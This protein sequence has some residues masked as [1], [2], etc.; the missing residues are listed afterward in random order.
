[1]KPVRAAA[2]LV[3]GVASI[4]L[5]SASAGQTRFTLTINIATRVGSGTG[6]VS[7]RPG[8]INCP[9]TCSATYLLGAVVTL[10][11]QAGP[12]SDFSGWPTACTVAGTTCTVAMTRD[13]TLDVSF[14]RLRSRQ[15][16]LLRDVQKPQGPPPPSPTILL[17]WGSCSPVPIRK[18]VTTNCPLYATIGNAQLGNDVRVDLSEPITDHCYVGS[19]SPRSTAIPEHT[20]PGRLLVTNVALTHGM[21][22]RASAAR[23]RTTVFLN[24]HARVE[25]QS[26][27]QRRE[28]EKVL[29]VPEEVEGVK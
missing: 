11:A 15:S 27:G 26:G 18:D 17:E 13:V 22:P 12:S 8:G 1:M 24:I 3:V 9:G 25:Y 2:L 23:G 29:S 16:D 4:M 28:D 19:I 6:T 21:C 7:S 10:S 20:Q 14:G 5:G